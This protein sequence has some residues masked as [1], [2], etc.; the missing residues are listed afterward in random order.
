MEIKQEQTEGVPYSTRPSPDEPCLKQHGC[1]SR[2]PENHLS[3]KTLCQL[4]ARHPTGVNGAATQ[5]PESQAKVDKFFLEENNNITYD[6]E[7]V[8]CP[9]DDTVQDKR[10]NANSHG[11]NRNSSRST[12]GSAVTSADSWTSD[13]SASPG[14]SGGSTRQPHQGMLSGHPSSQV[15]ESSSHTSTMLASA[16][17]PAN[18]SGIFRTPATL[19]DSSQ[20]HL[21]TG[22]QFS[23]L[24][25]STGG[26]GGGSSPLSYS[27]LHGA[28]PATVVAAQGSHLQAP[29]SAF[30]PQF[31]PHG[32]Y[33]HRSMLAAQYP[34]IE[35]YS[36]V[37]QSM[38]SQVQHASQTQL[39][40]NSYLSGQIPQYSILGGNQRSLS[41]STS[42]GPQVAPRHSPAAGQHSGDSAAR[43]RDIEGRSGGR[44][45]ST[46]YKDDRSHSLS[47][48][49][50][51]SGGKSVSF[52]DLPPRHD[53][54]CSK[55]QSDYKV[56]SGKEGSRKHRILTRPSDSV[57]ESSSVDVQSGSYSSNR[58]SDQP[59]PKRS[60]AGY[61]APLPPV[62]PR[63]ASV[64]QGVVEVGAGAPQSSNLHYPPH[65]MK[66]SII[67]LANG[68][69]K[70]VEDLQTDDFGQSAD[71]SS[72]LKIDSST[73]VRMEE[74]CDRS[75]VVLGFV[76]GEHRVQVTVEAT[77]E[78]PFFVFGQGWSSCDPDKT[79]ERYG[80]ECHRLSV[81]DICISLTHKEV[82]A[83]GA[84]LSQQQLRHQEENRHLQ[85]N[86]S[87]TLTFQ[88]P[89]SINKCSQGQGQM[90]FNVSSAENMEKS[91]Q[92]SPIDTVGDI[93]QDQH[94]VD[95]RP[96]RK[97]HW[98]SSDHNN[99]SVHND[100]KKQEKS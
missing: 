83:R 52:K 59:S 56:P 82:A 2:W 26:G 14:Q 80:L 21:S 63:G 1:R 87:P 6:V 24:Y 3:H 8:L 97:R 37:L 60:K 76:V 29:Y 70:R 35:S 86:R 73:V 81:G 66:G 19:V 17:S 67:Q 28:H 47:S 49:E 16:G 34:H 50:L 23:T 65:F 68:E 33:T 78:H 45:Y 27:N 22:S 64:E 11:H 54:L 43:E 62:N 53:S 15:Q 10:M 57:I 38:G 5:P 75:T 20:R 99:D 71:I 85:Q 100:Q 91:P 42:D 7:G 89:R 48:I 72:D 30:Y 9:G 39:P 74:K 31:S 46:Q 84:E 18:L 92:N 61:G 4:L 51:G 40:R 90:Y 25:S 58:S 79:L 41:V 95:N 36:A 77:V 93:N 12:N 88:T 32:G 13:V 44:E 96:P 55:D 69:L 94:P 98:S